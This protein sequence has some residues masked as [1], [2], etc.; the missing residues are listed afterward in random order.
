MATSSI[1][2]NKDGTGITLSVS[3]VSG[4]ASVQVAKYL[5]DVVKDPF[6]QI[7]ST[8]V[9]VA[10]SVVAL[11]VGSYV[12]VVTDDDGPSAPFGFRVTDGS[13]GTHHRCLE[14]V[15]EHVIALSLPSFPSDTD[16]HK[17][18]KR[19]INSFKEFTE[20]AGAGPKNQSRI[21]GVHYWKR[22]ERVR[23]TLNARQTVEYKIEMVLI[24]SRQGNNK[25]DPDW[26]YDRE[27]IVTS[28]SDCPLPSVNE[29]YGVNFLPGLLN[30]DAGKGTD[31][32]AQSM[33]FVFLSE[34]PSVAT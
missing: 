23:Q 26:T 32:E 7:L 24:R 20:W 5:G 16:K 11:D 18:H 15:R 2:D 17:L 29:V 8:S 22:P 6:S 19:P 27:R 25:S 3:G 1:V 13:L 31:V 10:S 33:Q 28:F 21:F 4:T 12:C 30:S 14:A 34:K 9:D